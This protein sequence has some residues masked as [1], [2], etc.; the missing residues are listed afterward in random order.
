MQGPKHEQPKLQ[1][2]STNEGWNEFHRRWETFPIGYGRQDAT[3]S[4]QLLKCTSE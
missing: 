2:N 4:G 1:L 3:A